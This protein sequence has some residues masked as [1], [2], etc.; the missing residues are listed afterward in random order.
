M[1]IAQPGS[2]SLQHCVV[3][4]RRIRSFGGSNGPDN[5][6]LP[7]EIRHEVEVGEV[8]L[9]RPTKAEQ[10]LQALL[11]CQRGGSHSGGLRPWQ[12]G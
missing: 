11:Q 2:E 12:P 4:R 9:H 7:I 3:V 10:P 1:A 8:R 6:L 5:G